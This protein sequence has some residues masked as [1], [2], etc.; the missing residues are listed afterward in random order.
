MRV[1]ITFI[2]FLGMVTHF[3]QKTNISI[4]LV[5]MVN[6]SAIERD[7]TNST[8]TQTI[9]TNDVCPQT[10]KTDHIVNKLSQLFIHFYSL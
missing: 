5:C 9:S 8:K 7:H 10:N 4:G 6:H 2:G 3:S 1:A